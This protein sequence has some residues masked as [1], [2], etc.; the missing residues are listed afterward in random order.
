MK[1][2]QRAME[3]LAARNAKSARNVDPGTSLAELPCASK[4]FHVLDQRIAFII[5]E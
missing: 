2:R 4:G 5:I 3:L 1:R